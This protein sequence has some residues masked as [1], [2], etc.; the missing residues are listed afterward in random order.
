[1]IMYC[2]HDNNP[3]HFTIIKNL[4]MI[5]LKF[6][7]HLMVNRSGFDQSDRSFS[8]IVWPLKSRIDILNISCAIALRWMLQDLADH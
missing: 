7:F 4:Q 2:F 8:R 6:A 3:I 5:D 1:M